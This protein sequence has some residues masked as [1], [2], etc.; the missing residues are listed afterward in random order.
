MQPTLSTPRPSS[1]M[2][3]RLSAGCVDGTMMAQHLWM[4]LAVVQ[5]C[6]EAAFH[7]E[8]NSDTSLCSAAVPA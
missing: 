3:T 2:K 8:V 7:E 4:I 5:R 6:S 1:S